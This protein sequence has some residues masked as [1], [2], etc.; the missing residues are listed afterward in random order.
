MT[1][2]WRC[3]SLFS[4]PGVSTPNL[5]QLHQPNFN[6]R[7][8]ERDVEGGAGKWKLGA[9]DLAWASLSLK[10]RSPEGLWLKDRDCSAESCVLA[11]PLFLCVDTEPL[12]GLCPE[13]LA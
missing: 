3:R 1:S 12:A 11:G 5:V 8:S 6:Q 2:L 9:N 7:F 4:V 13:V 10:N